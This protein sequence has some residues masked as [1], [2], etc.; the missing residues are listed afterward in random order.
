M[1][2]NALSQE[3]YNDKELYAQNIESVRSYAEMLQKAVES[4]KKAAA[5]ISAL[6]SGFRE[7][8]AAIKEV[9]SLLTPVIER[10]SE[11]R[12]KN[13][14]SETSVLMF[15]NELAKTKEPIDKLLEKIR[16]GFEEIASSDAFSKQNSEIIMLTDSYK[17]LADG[18]SL[19]L[20]ELLKLIDLYPQVAE[21]LAEEG[22]VS[23][24]NGSVLHEIALQKIKDRQD[25]TESIRKLET[26]IKTVSDAGV[27][28]G[29][30]YLPFEKAKTGAESAI[31]AYYLLADAIEAVKNGQALSSEVTNELAALY[32]KLSERVAVYGQ[33]VF[34]NIPF[35]ESLAKASKNTA[36]FVAESEI[37]MTNSVIENAKL[38]IEAMRAELSVKSDMMLAQNDDLVLNDTKTTVLRNKIAEQTKILNDASENLKCQQAA[39][40]GLT[41]ATKAGSGLSGKQTSVRA[42]TEALKENDKWYKKSLE[43]I[44]GLERAREGRTDYSEMLK[45][46][47][48]LKSEVE[49]RYAAFPQTVAQKCEEI[50]ILTAK[51][52]E[53]LA[54]KQ[55]H[56]AAELVDGQIA[57]NERLID[58]YKKADGLTFEG[59]EYRFGASEE[60]VIVEKNKQ[61]NENRINSL[62]S[63]EREMT[64]EED[65]ELRTRYKNRQEY[66]DRLY[67]LGIKALNAEREENLRLNEKDLSEQK[68]KLAAIEQLEKKLTE[69][70][71]AENNKKATDLK[72]RYAEEIRIAQ[73]AADAEIAVCRDRIT[74]IDKIIAQD[75]RGDKDEDELDN[76]GRLKAQLAYEHDDS[77][78]Y[79]L[80][81]EIALR[82]EEY[83]K[84]KRRES[85]EDEK[86]AL[87]DKLDLLGDSAQR[88]KTELES[89]RDA[90]VAILNSSYQAYVNKLEAELEELKGNGIKKI[91]ELQA[92]LDSEIE[93]Y[94]SMTKAAADSTEAERKIINLSQENILGDLLGKISSFAEAGRQAGQAYAE[95]FAKA[96]YDLPNANRE[97]SADSSGQN[98]AQFTVTQNFYAQTVTPSELSRAAERTA[99]AMARL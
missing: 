68:N 63:L 10:I 54:N 87:R 84:R 3:S 89:Q 36:E 55:L 12:G 37:I 15:F 76:I 71:K 91:D 73:E 18:Q 2:E 72:E 24:G 26:A 9:N 82:E 33:A 30:A 97:D 31:E 13:T 14:V 88:K 48:E 25:E 53:K 80:Q 66:T 58:Y 92:Q 70:L 46:Y 39:L 20:T 41:S 49:Q 45:R 90:E 43:N 44:A 75:D 1:P 69:K 8:P 67:S 57:Q 83:E 38:R 5:A 11:L 17:Q 93:I 28:L 29:N 61:L 19:S 4:S 98:S 22:D 27:S 77:N 6:S 86:A 7:L 96:I 99:E 74:Q 52:A 34:S 95:A 62:L 94:K 42:D 47:T 60:A 64:D 35:L 79:E 40:N 23:L 32:P 21:Y 51:T 16:S 65:K 78:K 81:K 56:I 50:D 85:L 59:S